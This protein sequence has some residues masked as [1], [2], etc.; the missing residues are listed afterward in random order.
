MRPG[1]LNGIEVTGPEGAA[2][3]KR[4][5]KKV[6]ARKK[7]KDFNVWAN[8]YATPYAK[9][10]FQD[11]YALARSEHSLDSGTKAVAE[12]KKVADKLVDTKKKQTEVAKESQKAA[13]QGDMVKA[14][15]LAKVEGKIAEKA[16]VIE[17]QL[18]TRVSE[19]VALAKAK[20]AGEKAKAE[21]NMKKASQAKR[22][23]H[24]TSV[25]AKH[26]SLYERGRAQ[27]VQK[28]KLKSLKDDQL[29]QYLKTLPKG[30]EKDAKIE[31]HRKMIAAKNIKD[32]QELA[33]YDSAEA[34]RIDGREATA[35]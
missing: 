6:I 5:Q 27:L 25:W 20:R 30:Q 23:P 10:L 9:R 12:V 1:Y 33:K 4:Y 11:P 13:Q 21:V 8:M 29:K 17:G 15:E 35:K 7:A 26:D 18:A 14:K 31:R 32:A 34:G 24:L 16:K 3:I 2:M 28:Q 22:Y 19:G